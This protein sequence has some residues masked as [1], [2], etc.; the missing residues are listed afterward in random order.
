MKRF[1]N[2]SFL[3]LV[4][5]GMA[6][7]GCNDDL[8]TSSYVK[9]NDEDVLGNVSQLE[10]VLTSAY[11]QLYFKATVCMPVFP[12]SRCMSMRVVPT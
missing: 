4:F 11:K 7:T 1:I 3:S 5:A 6:L 2:I 10:K 8:T 9:V 12:D